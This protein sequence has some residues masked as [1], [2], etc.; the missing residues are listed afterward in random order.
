MKLVAGF[1]ER[2]NLGKLLY[3]EFCDSAEQAITREKQLKN[4]HRDW[5]INLIKE[6]NPTMKDLY[7]DLGDPETSS[8]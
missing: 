8:G 7:E 6:Q 4:R 3:Y 2:Y 5:K 1:T